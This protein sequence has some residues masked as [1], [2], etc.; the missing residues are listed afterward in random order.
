MKNRF[1]SLLELFTEG[2]FQYYWHEDRELVTLSK[3]EIRKSYFPV[4]SAAENVFYFLPDGRDRAEI[5]PAQPRRH[6]HLQVAGGHPAGPRKKNRPWIGCCSISWSGSCAARGCF[7]TPA[8]VR[9]VRTMVLT[10]PGCAATTA[11]CCARPAGPTNAGSLGREELAYISWTANHA[12][13]DAATWSGRFVP[14]PLIRLMVGKIEYHGEFSLQSQP[15]PARIPLKKKEEDPCPPP[16]ESD[17]E[18]LA[19]VLSRQILKTTPSTLPT[20]V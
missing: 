8:A 3:G 10:G 16:C 17:Q 14:A 6:P 12:P 19:R 5:H 11:G 2:E 13:K 15:L 1:G 9:T 7:S 20:P 18:I 4:V